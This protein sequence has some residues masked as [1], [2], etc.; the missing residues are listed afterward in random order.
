MG[1]T[2]PGF[3]DDTPPAGPFIKTLIEQAFTA[4][5]ASDLPSVEA[6]DACKT[7]GEVAALYAPYFS[8]LYA[9]LW[10]ASLAHALI[11]VRE[12]SP[13]LAAAIAHQVKDALDDG[14]LYLELIW[15]WAD[16][17]GMEPQVLS[18]QA[19]AAVAQTNAERDHPLPLRKK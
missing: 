15:D 7:K 10:S 14:G 13:N 3:E 12:S 8:H 1:E 9:A 19:K 4:F 11:L 5:E 18:D 2:L 16:A 17:E 6:R